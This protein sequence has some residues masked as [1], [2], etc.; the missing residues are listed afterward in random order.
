MTFRLCGIAD[1]NAKRCGGLQKYSP[2]PF[3]SAAFPV[4]QGIRRQIRVLRLHQF[5]VPIVGIHTL[6]AGLPEGLL[7]P[8]RHP[9]RLVIPIN[10]PRLLHRP[11]Q[12]R[13]AREALR[14][15]AGRIVRVVGERRAHAVRLR[16]RGCVI[17]P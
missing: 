3:P 2:D 4:Q 7:L 6:R 5:I 14:T 9:P 13:D 10:V 12:M 8:T 1:V 11:A 16:Q 17:C 15:V